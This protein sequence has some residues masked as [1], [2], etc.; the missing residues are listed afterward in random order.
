MNVFLLKT[1]GNQIS[2]VTFTEFKVGD[3]VNVL[4]FHQGLSYGERG[5]I[6]TNVVL[7]F[8]V[9]QI[10]G[11]IGL[12]RYFFLPLKMLILDI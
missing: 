5:Q 1:I 9:I 6:L 4:N 11:N 12:L 10:M 7:D 2:F 3:E 8:S